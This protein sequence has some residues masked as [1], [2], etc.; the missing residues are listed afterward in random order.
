MLVV[1]ETGF[2][3]KGTKSAGVAARYSGTVG[4]I[5]NGQIGV[6]LVSATRSAAVLLDR[7]LYLP[8]DWEKDPERCQEAEVPEER[9]KRIPKPTLAKQMLTHAFAHGVQA[10]WVTGDTVY[11][12]DDKLRSWLEERLQPSGLAVPLREPYWAHPSRRFCRG[13]LACRE[14]AAL[15]RGR[16]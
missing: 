7:E 6:F 15:V 9:R 3:K 12:G 1:D 4:K 11:G 14:V 13:D 10:T 8:A 2:L 5:A 16:S